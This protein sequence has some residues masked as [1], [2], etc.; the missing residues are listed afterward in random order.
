M[1]CPSSRETIAAWHVMPPESVAIAAARRINGTQS[2][3]VI[4]RDEH[5]A[6]VEPAGVGERA[7]HADRPARSARRRAEPTHQNGGR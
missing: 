3:A 5:V 2:G 7:E 1:G 4:A 6:V